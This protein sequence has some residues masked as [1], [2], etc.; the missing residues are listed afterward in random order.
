[1]NKRALFHGFWQKLGSI[2]VIAGL[3]LCAL[4]A[5]GYLAGARLNMTTSLPM[6]LY[7]VSGQAIQRGVYVRF[8][9]PAIGAFA[10]AKERGYLHVGSC[11]SG[12][13]P[14][15]KRVS[16]VPGD[17]IDIDMR[18]V[19]VNGVDL[20]FSAAQ[21]SDRAGRSLPRPDRSH[22]VLTAS[23]L[24]VMSDTNPRSFDSRYFGP[25]ERA[26]V[27]DVIRPVVTWGYGGTLQRLAGSEAEKNSHG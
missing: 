7:W 9:P 22:V 4:L 19:R 3:A 21:T 26:W 18:E 5:L 23:Q 10:E 14:L 15:L 25:I 27:K 17:T 2:I 12:Y 20:P 6:G 13:V 16:G 1:M 8:C 24:W 11:P